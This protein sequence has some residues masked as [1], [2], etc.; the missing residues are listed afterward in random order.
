M[1]EVVNRSTSNR[2]SSSPSTSRSASTNSVWI[3]RRK[4]SIRSAQYRISIQRIDKSFHIR[5]PLPRA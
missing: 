3:S 4:K 2:S 5:R 1:N